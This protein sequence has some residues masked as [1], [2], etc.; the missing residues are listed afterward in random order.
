MFAL[1]M[2]FIVSAAF[3]AI[4]T[5]AVI[6]AAAFHSFGRIREVEPDMAWFAALTLLGAAMLSVSFAHR[7]YP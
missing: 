1:E 3:L 2:R 5:M 6:A 4:A 7:I